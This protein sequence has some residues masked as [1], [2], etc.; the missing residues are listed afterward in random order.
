M[1]LVPAKLRGLGAA[2][3]GLLQLPALAVQVHRAPEPTRGWRRR[4]HGLHEGHVACAPLRLRLG[5]AIHL[6][7]VV[8]E[9]EL[10]L[11]VL[12]VVCVC[13]CALGGVVS[14]RECDS[15]VLCSK[16]M[17]RVS[18]FKPSDIFIFTAVLT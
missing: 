13:A 8:C 9:P 3:G 12:L 7:C 1:G 16:C 5:I 10:T 2:R 17:Y 11:R 14:I 15:V 18:G 4:R 6:A